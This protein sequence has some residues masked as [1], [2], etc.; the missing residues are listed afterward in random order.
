MFR[1][2]YQYMLDGISYFTIRF[3]DIPAGYGEVDVTINDDG[4]ERSCS[5]V[6]GN[7][8]FS[9]MESTTGGKLDTISPS[10]QWYMLEK[11]DTW[12]G[13]YGYE[14]YYPRPPERRSHKTPPF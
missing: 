3:T 1:D 7:L 14:A 13:A 2:R 5:M 8:A 11:V 12:K 4:I 6:A 10:P 9:V